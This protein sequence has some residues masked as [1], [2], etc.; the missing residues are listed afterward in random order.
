MT[1]VSQSDGK[2][3]GAKKDLNN[4]LLREKRPRRVHSHL[5]PMADVLQSLLENGKSGLSDGFTRFRLEKEWLQV[6]GPTI[7]AQTLPATYYRGVLY[8]WVSHPTWQQQL[9]FLQDAIIEKVN[10]HL[11]KPWVKSL[12]FTTNKRAAGALPEEPAQ[13]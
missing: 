7:G 9:W 5:L 13:E 3:P 2:P 6:V 11:G 8:I 4:L 12:R 1:P 10:T